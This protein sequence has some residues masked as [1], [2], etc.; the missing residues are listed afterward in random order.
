M[1]AVLVEVDVSGVDAQAGLRGL[2]EQIVPVISSLP[3][4]RSGTWL[5]GS[6]D[7]V[8]L[9]LTL[10]DTKADADR[11]A[12]QF[13]VGANPQQE[14]SVVRCEVREVAATA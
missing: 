14:A 5:T 7:G 4:F 8:G 3:G 10:W 11:M 6:A 9:S 2:R 12:D 13:G 1:Y